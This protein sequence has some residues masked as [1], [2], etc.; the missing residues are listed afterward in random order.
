MGFL[1][2][3]SLGKCIERT[4]ADKKI[5]RLPP[6]PPCL[7]V[8]LLERKC[9]SRFEKSECDIQSCLFS[10]L[11]ERLRPCRDCHFPSRLLTHAASK[12]QCLTRDPT[13]IVGSEKYGCARDI[14]RLPDAPPEWSL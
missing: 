10:E 9:R 5:D 13:R 14:L 6:S 1:R 11:F 7:V 12:N 2:N 3:P 8:G 4:M